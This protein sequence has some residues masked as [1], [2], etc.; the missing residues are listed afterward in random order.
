MRF[1]YLNDLLEEREGREREGKRAG[2]KD[3]RGITVRLVANKCRQGRKYE[4][5]LI[6]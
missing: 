5:D 4:Q 2:G 1:F 3:E 6:M